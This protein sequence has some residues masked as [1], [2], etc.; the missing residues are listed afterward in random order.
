[1]P[2]PPPLVGPGELRDALGDE[3]VRVFDATVFLRRAVDGGPYTV[4][5]GR[6]VDGG[7]NRFRPSAELTT[8]LNDGG[9]RTD[10]PVIAYYGGGI[11]ATV[12]LFA[13]SLTGRDDARL[14]DG[15][16]TEWSAH[17]DLPLVTG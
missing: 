11:S 2:L 1:M 3:R 10:Q 9:V 14:Y 6:E 16:L 7:T 15:S 12:D 17:P 8:A 13:L 4:E 5:S